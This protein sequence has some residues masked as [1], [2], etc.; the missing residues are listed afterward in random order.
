MKFE[1]WQI[2]ECY[3]VM[4]ST[5]PYPLGLLIQKYQV[6]QVIALDFK[7][8][9]GEEYLYIMDDTE[10]YVIHRELGEVQGTLNREPPS[11]SA[12]RG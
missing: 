8:K 11:T 1:D 7:K 2:G 12:D 4:I 6:D 3:D 5:G 9:S 10:T